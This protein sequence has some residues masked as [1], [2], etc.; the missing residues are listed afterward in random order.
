MPFAALKV[1]ELSR[2]TGLTI[3]T[4]HHYDAIGLLKPSLHTEAGHRLYTAGDV[5]RLQRI[6]SLR[7]LGFGLEQVRDCLTDPDLSPRRV[8]VLHAARLGEQIEHLQRLKQRLEALA[9][10]LDRTEAASVE[11]FLSV[12]QEMTMIEKYYTPEQL[13]QLKQRAGT[14]SA[15]RIREVEAEWPR[16]MAQVK[17]EMDKG[18]DPASEVVQQ[19]ARRWEGLVN[20][21]TGGD[22]GI[23]QSL[24]AMWETEPTIH[25]MDTGPVREMRAYID[26]ALAA[27]KKT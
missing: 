14:V 19:L 18:T 2:R 25:G 11:E 9:E 12:I 20:E 17:A 7:E 6:K 23:F 10:V 3:R 15:E 22:P 26:R 21:F 8:L 4:L 24:K 27:A 16:L 5:A 1:G 13:E